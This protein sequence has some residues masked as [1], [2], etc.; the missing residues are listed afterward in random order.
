MLAKDDIRLYSCIRS[1]NY[2]KKVWSITEVR[3]DDYRAQTLDQSDEA[4]FKKTDPAVEVTLNSDV[5]AWYDDRRTEL[6][7]ELLTSM[8]LVNRAIEN[9][10]F[11]ES[12]R[13][14]REASS[15]LVDGYDY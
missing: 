3:E 1:S 6:L 10:N 11:I 14:L 2:P 8:S 9:L 13:L 7:K 4:A 5:R 15:E 12:R